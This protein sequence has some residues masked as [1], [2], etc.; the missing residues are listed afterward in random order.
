MQFKL[1]IGAM[2]VF[3]I[4]GGTSALALDIRGK[5][6]SDADAWTYKTIYR[7]PQAPETWST[8]VYWEYRYRGSIEMEAEQETYGVFEVRS[9]NDTVHSYVKLYLP[10]ENAPSMH[11]E[12]WKSQRGVEV[13]RRHT[14]GVNIPQ[15]IQHA[16]VPLDRPVFPLQPGGRRVFEDS[17][18]ISDNIRRTRILVQTVEV[19]TMEIEGFGV[20]SG[21]EV[22]CSDEAGMVLFRQ[23]YSGE[24]PWPLWGETADKRYWLVKE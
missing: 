17:R 11:I 14:Y 8:P 3:L 19:Q 23:F 9:K 21:L 1:L 18:T 6:H 12:H 22:S 5:A 4:G 16:L 7:M 24:S 10:L 2:I 20:V 13:H 15:P